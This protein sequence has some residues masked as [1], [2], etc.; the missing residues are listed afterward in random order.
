MK[1]SIDTRTGLSRAL[2]SVIIKQDIR[3]LAGE[4]VDK[5]GHKKANRSTSS[6]ANEEKQNERP[7]KVGCK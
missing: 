2:I 5:V 7:N 6:L 3:Y 4:N 1:V